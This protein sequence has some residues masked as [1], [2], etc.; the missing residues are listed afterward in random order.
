[1]IM[2][3]CCAWD[4]RLNVTLFNWPHHELEHRLPQRMVSQPRHAPQTF[5]LEIAF[6]CLRMHAHTLTYKLLQPRRTAYTKALKHI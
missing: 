2:G 4:P 3:R 6:F 5:K 1:M